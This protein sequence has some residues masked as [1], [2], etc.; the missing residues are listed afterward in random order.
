MWLRKTEVIFGGL[1]SFSYDC[2][3]WA[4]WPVGFLHSNLYDNKNPRKKTSWDRK[5]HSWKP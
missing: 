3:D 5:G 4:E 1:A 2:Y